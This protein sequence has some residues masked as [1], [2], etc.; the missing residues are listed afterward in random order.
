MRLGSISRCVCLVTL[1]LLAS[2]PAD[3][4]IVINEV[5]Y[6]PDGSDTGLEF[7][8][9]SNCGREG[10]PLAS[11][12]LESG[13][14]ASP[15]D[16]TVEWIGGDFDY[17]E[18]GAIFLI[19]EADVQPA[20]DH[21]TAL[22]LQNGPDGLRLTDGHKVVDVVGWGEPLFQEYYEGSP[23]ADAPSGNSLARVPDCFDRDDNSVDFAACPTPTP[24]RRNVFE[25][26]LA[27]RVAHAGEVVLDASEP[28]EVRCTIRNAGS[29]PVDAYEAVVELTVGAAADA[30]SQTAVAAALAPRDSASVVL[31][32]TSPQPGYHRAVATTILQGD[33]DASNDSS[34]TS[35]TVQRE[36]GL[37]VVNEIMYSPDEGSTEWIE[38]VNVT[39]APVVPDGWLV[40]DGQE[41]HAVESAQADSVA[42][43]PAGGLA[44]I[45]REPNLLAG[46]VPFECPVFGTDGWEALSSDDSIVILDEYSTPVDRLAYTDDWGGARG[47]SLERVRADMP[48]DDPNNW[49]SSVAPSGATPGRPNSIRLSVL[50]S[51][52]RLDVSPNPFT[53]DGD[54]SADR[55]LITY[56]L[57][58]ATA[59]VRLSV[60]D[61]RGRCRAILRDHAATAST[62]QLLWDGTGE[63]GAL[64]PTGLYVLLLEALNARAGV[65]VKEKAAVGLVR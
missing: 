3:A 14:G 45:A 47:V 48:A 25:T 36:G 38:L 10:V 11:W 41:F 12:V 15:D 30:V 23:A 22:D 62:G 32:W 6:D 40:G 19:G 5:L 55:T 29:L 39:R 1:S 60:Y 53:P 24:G 59:L 50:P 17:L 34:E 7:A 31:A 64:L 13:N 61:G 57:P 51:S 20:P 21:V 18:P 9:L 63:G 4:Q 49:G 52:G 26:D 56:G 42:A 27:T 16:W 2:G 58:V 65:L 44:V 54:G 8:E 35:F 43:I 33:E 28:V 46:S 37:L